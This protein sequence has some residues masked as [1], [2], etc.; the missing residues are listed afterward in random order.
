[1]KKI[2]II[3][4]PNLNF[5]GIRQKEIYGSKYLEDINRRI[6][7][8]AQKFGFETIFF[9][10]NSEGAIIDKIQKC[11][12]N[13]IDGII[14]NAGAY[15]HYSYAIRDAIASVSIPTIEVHLSNIY[16]REPFREKSVIAPV[17]IGQITGFGEYSYIMALD[18][19]NNI[20]NKSTTTF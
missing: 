6:S 11:F 14:I 15:T 9:C 20:L 18:Y 17:C 13:E 10:S 5:L 3:N 4:G 7:K 8:E 12:F 16:A 19:F 2:A 1:M